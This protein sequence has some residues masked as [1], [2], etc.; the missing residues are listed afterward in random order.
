MRGLVAVVVAAM[1]VAACSM[2]G[3][4]E[5]TAGS[6]GESLS[7]FIPGMPSFDPSNPEAAQAEFRRQEQQAQERIAECMAEQG[8]EYIPYV[9]N[10]E[11]MNFEEADYVEEFGFGFATELLVD[12]E[13]MEARMEAEMA[14][15]PNQAIV[16]AMSPE[17]QEAYYEALYGPQPEID[18]ETMS[19]EEIQ[20]AFENFEPSGC[21]TE[22]YEEVFDQGAAQA[23]Y[24]EFGAQLEEFFRRAESDPRIQELDDKWAACM[25]EKGY[26]FQRRS[27]AELSI[28]RQLEAVGV[29]TDLE[30][31]PDGEL[32]GFGMEGLGP[33]D[34]R[35]SE[36][37]AIAEEELA[38]AKATFECEEG[39][40]EVY[41]EV[42]RELEREFI[43]QH[44]AELERFRKE[45]GG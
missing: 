1:F 9:P 4:S 37:E 20:A 22:A 26:D 17:E 31:S 45:H 30:V 13:E 38:V 2:V 12:P 7:D 33:D 29:V 41:Q 6:Q 11:E 23:F 35:R 39:L 16:E 44:R 21:Q 42:Y 5:T 40:D 19:E 28:L 32:M 15:D 27:D 10:F 8:F 14:Q 25:K 18:P 43:E 36:V 3:S 34:P 24:E